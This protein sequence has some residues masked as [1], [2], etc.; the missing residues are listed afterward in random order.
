MKLIL[1]TKEGWTSLTDLSAEV[2]Y[3]NDHVLRPDVK[4]KAGVEA[5]GTIFLEIIRD[6]PVSDPPAYV[7][8]IGDYAYLAEPSEVGYAEADWWADVEARNG[9]HWQGH[10]TDIE[11]ADDYERENGDLPTLKVLAVAQYRRNLI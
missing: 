3:V 7:V 8:R 5:D 9:G 2:Q 11:T 6:E 10:I 1:D 4:V